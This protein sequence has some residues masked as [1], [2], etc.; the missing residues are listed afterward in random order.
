MNKCT[1]EGQDSAIPEASSLEAA[2]II[3]YFQVLN[4]NQLGKKTESH[5][6]NTRGEDCHGTP[7]PLIGCKSAFIIGCPF[8]NSSQTLEAMGF[9]AGLV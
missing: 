4:A 9:V 6:S 5:N 3:N 7:K 2:Q 1:S 8:P